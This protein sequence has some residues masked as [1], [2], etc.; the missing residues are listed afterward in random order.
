M[1]NYPTNRWRPSAVTVLTVKVTTLDIVHYFVKISHRFGE[2]IYFLQL[3]KK[4]YIQPLNLH[5]YKN[6]SWAF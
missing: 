6:I 5:L 3:L 4:I 2:L 1:V